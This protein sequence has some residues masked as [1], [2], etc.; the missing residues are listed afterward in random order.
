MGGYGNG[1]G[2]GGGQ[3]GGYSGNS[4]G[5]Y[6]GGRSRSGIKFK[7]IIAILLIVAI[8]VT[9]VI[10]ASNSKNPGSGIDDDGFV[11]GI[12]PVT[13][14][15]IKVGDTL[16][17][18]YNTNDENIDETKLIW[19]SD[20]E[21]IMTVSTTGLVRALEIGDATITLKYDGTA[22]V[23]TAKLQVIP[24]DDVDNETNTLT[25]IKISKPPSTILTVGERLELSFET[26]PADI[27]KNKVIWSSLAE[28]V[29]TVDQESG[30]ITAVSIGTA[31]TIKLEYEGSA[32]SDT[33]EFTVID[34]LSNINIEK[35][36]ITHIYIGVKMKRL[37]Y[38]VNMQSGDAIN[39]QKLIWESS[40]PSILSLD[41]EGNIEAKGS[42]TATIT[43]GYEGSAMVSN[44]IS[45]KVESSIYNVLI[46]NTM[47]MTG[48]D[49]IEQYVYFSDYFV[50]DSVVFADGVPNI[51]YTVYNN[52][53]APIGGNTPGSGSTLVVAYAEIN[54]IVFKYSAGNTGE[55]TLKWKISSLS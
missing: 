55:C 47:K 32:L 40:D 5:G 36:N 29:I 8:I 12:K 54:R 14:T 27:D 28:D 23:D 26:V 19:S 46:E 39:Q 42:G 21:D 43:L 3:G 10:V 30:I 17:L 35:P 11:L 41:T 34:I 52:L 4:Q 51:S 50:D 2:Y 6:G 45:F 1:G 25:D 24:N 38:D 33:L 22:K 16:Q 18:D 31:A 7:L 9:V 37:G 49:P 53:G 20:D 15:E 13:N 44:A 48:S